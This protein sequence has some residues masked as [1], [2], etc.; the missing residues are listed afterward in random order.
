M[1]VTRNPTT[2]RFRYQL[3]RAIQVGDPSGA[4]RAMGELVYEG[5]AAAFDNYGWL[6]IRLRRDVRGG[7]RYFRQ[8]AKLG[9]A[10]AMQSLA[11]LMIKGQIRESYPGEALTLLYGAAESGS[12]DAQTMVAEYEGEQRSG[13][14]AADILRGI[15]GGVLGAVNR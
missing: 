15:V 8:G 1:A 4:E 11:E 6:A 9:N 2:T 12:A 7:E 5:Y 13:K 3:A 10:D 14:A